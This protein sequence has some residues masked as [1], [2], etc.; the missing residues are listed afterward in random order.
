MKQRFLHLIAFFAFLTSAAS[1]FAYSFSG[2]KYYTIDGVEYYVRFDN[3]EQ[4]CQIYYIYSNLTCTSYKYPASFTVQDAEWP[5]VSIRGGSSEQ[6][7]VTKLEF[8]DCVKELGQV[9]SYFPNV[10]VFDIPSSV[11]RFFDNPFYGRQYTTVKLHTLT[12]PECTSSLTGSSGYHVKMYVPAE[13]FKTYIKADYYEDQCIVADNWDQKDVYTTVKTGKVD[14]GE[15]G[16]IVVSDRLPD[17]RTYAEVNKLIVESGHI[18]ADDFYQIRQMRNLVYLD[19]S[20]LTI[21]QLPE[22][23]LFDCW[24]IET[25]LLPQSLKYIRDSAF[26]GCGIRQIA[27]PDGLEEISGGYNFRNCDFLTS[28]SIPDGVK[29]LDTQVCYSCD[30]LHSVKLP[31]YLEYLG[32]EAFHYCDLYDVNIPGTLKVVPSRCF[33]SNANLAQVTFNEGTQKIDGYAFYDCTSLNN[34]VTP[35]SLRTIEVVA[36]GVCSSLENLTLTEG[37]EYINNSFNNCSSLKNVVL[38]SSLL[39]CINSP[40][41]NC[42][43]ETITSYALIP[44]TVK[45][46][47]P[48]YSAGNIELKVPL[49]SFQ[50]YMT[51]PGWLEYQDH[52]SIADHL[53]ENLYITKDFEFVL[54]QEQLD[55][56]PFYKPNLHMLYNEDE[57]DDGFGHVKYERGNLTVG[58]TS[59]KL[60]ITDFQMYFSP[61]AKVSADKSLFYSSSNSYDYDYYR[62]KYN[63]NALVVK[64]E[65]RAENQTIKL[66]LRND[67]WH[68]ISFP[69][70]VDVKHF[71]PVDANTQWVIREYDGKARA[72]QDFDHTW[73]T[74]AKDGMLL[75]NRGYIVKCYNNENAS[76][77]YV[78]EFTVKPMDYNITEQDL[79]K[80]NPVDITLYKYDKDYNGNDA[81]GHNSSWNLIGNPYPCFY[82]TR[83][84]SSAASFLIWDS[85][86][87]TYQAF[88]IKDDKYILNPGE[89]FFMQLPSDIKVDNNDN[90]ILHLD[91]LGRQTYRN[92]NDLKDNGSSLAKEEGL[93]RLVYNLSISNG[94]HSD[95]TRVVLNEDALLKYEAGRDVSKFKSEKMENP[96]LWTMGGSV[97][98]AI[99]ERPVREGVVELRVRV[100]IDGFYTIN[101]NENSAGSVFLLDREMGTTTEVSADRPYQFFAKAGEI[102]GRFQ[103]QFRAPEATA[104]A[105]V[106]G[107]ESE[108][109]RYDLSGK[110]ISATQKGIVIE[111]GKKVLK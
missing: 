106:E 100:G 95:R 49:W 12:P 10:E 15:L 110:K 23:A 30:K 62:T 53:P 40:F 45:N 94:T 83:Y 88:N 67:Q 107:A 102:A 96:Q 99:N 43:V 5:V 27:L 89:A 28:L 76:S 70:D 90:G 42:P 22:S 105:G 101:L 54:R 98:Y 7:S 33:Y 41:Y 73:K 82:D 47:I 104:I 21:E 17:I 61:Y 91:S 38:P 71:L 11:E 97:E 109:V 35:A 68:F 20:G 85:Y 87:D 19:L 66:L 8:P 46:V 26:R 92:P 29:R 48:T 74:V 78:V 37:L 64:G 57:I 80:P 3:A 86:N 77:P 60:N 69:F 63:P 58:S 2:G 50:E 111:K 32:S 39:Y 16:Y 4:V 44:P 72:A 56:N 52:L 51:T 103:I 25:V 1:A 75:K 9:F 93:S 55:K 36:F 59:G 65:M 31:Q 81:E 14:D 24:Q 13:S 79:F 84:I 34:V 18:N 108:A 6:K